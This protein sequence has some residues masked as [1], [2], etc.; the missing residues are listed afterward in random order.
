LLDPLVDTAVKFGDGTVTGSIARSGTFGG[1]ALIFGVGTNI[2]TLKDAL[3]KIGIFTEAAIVAP[4]ATALE[5]EAEARA[6]SA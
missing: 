2:A 3:R 4:A 1:A 5:A 6:G